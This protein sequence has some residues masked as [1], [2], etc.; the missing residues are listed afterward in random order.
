MHFG[1]DLHT[2]VE[3][4]VGSGADDQG[5]I[6]APACPAWRRSVLAID[7]HNIL[8]R[9]PRATSKWSRVAAVGWVH[10]PAGNLGMAARS[11]GGV[12]S[13]AR[14]QPRDG[15]AQRGGG[16]I[17]GAVDSLGTAGGGGGGRGS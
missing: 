7:H 2:F 11:G 4:I 14:G 17:H 15:R 16:G 9:A 5:W 10:G 13:R 3:V 12:G 8:T 6:R 1:Q